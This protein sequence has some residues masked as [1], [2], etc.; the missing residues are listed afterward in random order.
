MS[1]LIYCDI[2]DCRNTDH[3]YDKTIYWINAGVSRQAFGNNEI[4]HICEHC[5]NLD[6]SLND[7]DFEIDED[8]ISLK[9][10]R[11]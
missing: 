10:T 2:D 8:S 5:L 11:Q 3:S 6:D 9:E 7:K 4:N 1:T